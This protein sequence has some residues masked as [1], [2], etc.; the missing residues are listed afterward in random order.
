MRELL[1]ALSGGAHGAGRQDMHGAA[2][3][4]DASAA[5]SAEGGAAEAEAQCAELGEIFERYQL[6]PALLD[7]HLEPWLAQLFAPIKANDPGPAA[8]A[9]GQFYGYLYLGLYF[10][11][12]GDKKKS[13]DYI[14]K[15]TKG[16]EAHGYMGQVDRVHHEWLQQK[17]VNKEVKPEK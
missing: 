3:V 7:P 13:A 17:P 15:A 11:A 4:A 16:H 10:E 5:A 14:V 8:L 1:P 6:Q 2:R 12:Q 9:R